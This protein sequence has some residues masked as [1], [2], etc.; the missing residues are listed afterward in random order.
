MLCDDCKKKQASV[1][2][3]QI[4]NNQKVDKHL[5]NQCA[6]GYGH[7]GLA[8]NSQFT[9]HDFL[10][11]MFTSGAGDNALRSSTGCSNCGMTYQD[12]SRSGKFGCSNCYSS[13]GSRVDPLLRRIH[14][15]TGHIGKIPRRTGG[16]LEMKQKIKKLRHDLERHVV[17]EEYEQAAKVRD[18]IRVLEQKQHPGKEEEEK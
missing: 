9:V 16:E 4:T 6:Q 12:F 14:G 2:I 7:L 10:K 8:M 13:F 17:Q 15:C 3:T 5:C 1:H 18:A 11:N